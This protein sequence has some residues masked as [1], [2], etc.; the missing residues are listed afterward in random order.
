M[1]FYIMDQRKEGWVGAG[2][3]QKFQ[4]VSQGCWCPLTPQE[5]GWEG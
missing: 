2:R 3:P 1:C 5:P 4:Q